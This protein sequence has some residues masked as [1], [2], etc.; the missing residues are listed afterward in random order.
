MEKAYKIKVDMK[1]NNGLY[2]GFVQYDNK[3]NIL[4]INLTEGIRILEIKDYEEIY[5]LML[6]PDM[7]TLKLDCQVSEDNKQLKIVLT[8]GTLC[9]PGILQCEIKI[10][11]KD[12]VLTS[13]EFYLQVRKGIGTSGKDTFISNP[14]MISKDGY[15]P[16]VGIDFFTEADKQEML[17]KIGKMSVARITEEDIAKMF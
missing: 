16:K 9:Q 2:T 7:K 8:D 1:N 10:I 17:E 11:N 13:G 3:T 12:Y 5:C 6:R 4:Y 14:F 15:T